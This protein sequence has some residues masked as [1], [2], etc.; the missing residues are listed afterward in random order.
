MSIPILVLPIPLTEKD[1]TC[2]R[3]QGP[4]NIYFGPIVI[5][6]LPV[7]TCTYCNWTERFEPEG[8]KK[9]PVIAENGADGLYCNSCNMFCSFVEPNRGNQYICPSCR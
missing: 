1:R 9:K 6:K 4:C 3:C 2:L 5:G 7:K 8:M